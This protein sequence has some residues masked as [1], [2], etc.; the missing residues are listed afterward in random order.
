MI[1]NGSKLYCLTGR[2]NELGVILSTSRWWGLMELKMVKG[3]EICVHVPSFEHDANHCHLSS[4]NIIL[5]HI[6]TTVAM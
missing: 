2:V 3:G 4:N 5:H 1:L 6:T